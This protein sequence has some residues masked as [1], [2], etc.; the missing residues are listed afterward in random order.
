MSSFKISRFKYLCFRCSCFLNH[1][2]FLLRCKSACVIPKFINIRYNLHPIF[3]VR[4]AL[5]RSKFAMLM[6][7][8]QDV[9]QSISSIESELYSLH[10]H[11]SNFIPDFSSFEKRNYAYVEFQFARHKTIL[12]KCSHL[13]LNSVILPRFLLRPLFL[14]FRILLSIFPP[15]LSLFLNVINSL[16]VLISLVLLKF[17]SL[18]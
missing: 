18:T 14:S 8:T 15:I 2:N 17:L 10:L 13:F 7:V 12:N 1:P 16:L 4:K 6:A 11:P 5:I 3:R 9:R